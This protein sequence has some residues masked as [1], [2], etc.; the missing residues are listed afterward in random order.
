MA[1][2]G[3]G[4]LMFMDAIGLRPA[5]TAIADRIAGWG[6]V[7][8]V[9]NVF[10]RNGRVVELAPTGDLREP[11][12]REAF[13]AGAMRWVRQLTPDLSGPDTVAYLRHL[14][15]LPGVTGS[16]VAVTGYCMGARLAVRAAGADPDVV[17][18]AGFHGGG[19]VTGEIDSPHRALAT[20]RAQFLFRH[21][22]RDPSMPSE[23]IAALGEAL[24]A[25]GLTASN[26][27]YP[28]AAHGYTMSDTAVYDAGAAERHFSELKALLDRALPV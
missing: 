7:V 16:Q 17:A 18:C 1:G 10:H 25:V 3:P 28:G 22:D 24:D 21:A 4:V 23:A 14:R 20:A 11:G 12:A 5:L 8:L 26:Q 27:V 19:L 9:P 13:F 6:Y 2:R 15:S